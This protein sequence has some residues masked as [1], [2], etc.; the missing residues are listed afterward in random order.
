ML[1]DQITA[2]M[3]NAMKAGDTERLGVLRMLA[4]SI[5]NRQIEKRGKGG[6]DEELT[7]DEVLEVLSREAKKSRES[8]ELF[9]KGGRTDLSDVEQKE[10]KIVE[11]YLPAQMGEAEIK[12]VIKKTAE[13]TEPAEFG[14][15]MKE[16]MK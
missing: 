9:V 14:A 16:V 1:K 13:K 5:N 7:D 3:K 6:V 11:A 2:D 8:I 12:A 15:V 10:L 4:S